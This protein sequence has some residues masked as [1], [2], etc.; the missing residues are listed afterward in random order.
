ML[1]CRLSFRHP[2][3]V[4]S[5]CDIDDRVTLRIDNVGISIE[6]G[7]DTCFV[8]GATEGIWLAE[9]QDSCQPEQLSLMKESVR[10]IHKKGASRA[11]VN[12]GERSIDVDSRDGEFR[13]SRRQIP[14][15][16]YVPQA[17]TT[18]TAKDG[19][20]EESRGKAQDSSLR[21]NFIS[22]TKSREP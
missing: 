20:S 1:R 8:R 16:A 4:R 17:D 11:A 2:W 14:I 12:F 21:P 6:A 3:R 22:T 19:G 10:A 15:P 5:L 9:Q 7:T 18:E 13:P